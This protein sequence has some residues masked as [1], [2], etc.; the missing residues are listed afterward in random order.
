M[1]FVAPGVVVLAAPAAAGASA[2]LSPGV[3]VGNVA[4]LRHW[5]RRARVVEVAVAEPR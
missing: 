2:A 4:L 1:R 5:Q 3:G